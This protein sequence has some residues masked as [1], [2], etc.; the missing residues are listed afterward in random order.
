VHKAALDPEA[1]WGKFARDSPLEGDGFELSVPVA[2]EPVFIAEGELRGDRW[3]AKKIWRGTD[4]SNPSPSSGVSGANRAA[5]EAPWQ[6]RPP[7]QIRRSASG[8]CA[9]WSKTIGDGTRSRIGMISMI[10]AA[11]ALIWMCHPSSLT[12][13]DSGSIISG[14]VAPAGA[15]LKRIPRPHA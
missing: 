4:G 1:V 9:R 5:A 13:F 3:A 2:R 8:M 12:R 11:G 7:L 10:F 6:L 14:V 15:K